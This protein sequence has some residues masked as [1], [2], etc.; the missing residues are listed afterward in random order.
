ML[1]GAFNNASSAMMAMSYGMGSI[2]Q[3]ISN[4]NTVGYKRKDTEF[5]TM[6]SESHSAPQTP[7][8][9]LSIFGVRPAD[10]TMVSQ[11]GQSIAGNS[12]SDL[13]INGRGFFI[14]SQPD[15]TGE[16]Q[17]SLSLTDNQ[18]ILYTRA[19]DFRE[20]AIGTAGTGTA[21]SSSSPSSSPGEAQKRY[22]VTAGGQFLMG[23][24]ADAWGRIPGVNTTYSSPVAASSGSSSAS[25]TLVPISVQPN[26]T[27]DGVT[28][29]IIQPVMNIPA[30]LEQTNGS[31]RTSTTVTDP[32]AGTHTMDVQWARDATD[33]NAWTVTY[34]LGDGSGT[35]A[36][37]TAVTYDSQGDILTPTGGL[38]QP[39]VAWQPLYGGVSA[40][41]AA[42]DLA[43][44]DAPLE[45][46]S[47]TFTIYDEKFNPQSVVAEFEHTGTDAWNMRIRPQSH[48]VETTNATT[49]ADVTATITGA[50]SAITYTSTTGTTTT[51]TAGVESVPIVFDGAGQ[52]VSPTDMTFTVDWTVSPA[53]TVLAPG[54]N[55][56]EVDMTKLT[57]FSD[58]TKKVF[59]KSVEQDGYGSGQL[60]N[61][62]FL[63][64]GELVGHFTNG[65]ARTLY[66]VPVATF[67]AP[68]SLESVSGTMFRYT[69]EAGEVSVAEIA[70]QGSG[71][72]MVA[73][74]LEAS[75]VE[76]EDE[77][78]RMIITQKAYSSNATVFKTADEMT[79]TARDLKG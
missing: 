9:G 17:T 39:T 23:W 58:P 70:D 65:N 30:N 6:L 28:T 27:L 59:I 7:G 2:S 52:I 69:A 68:N 64:T 19:G 51:T 78:T 18:N 72:S 77:F 46:E 67:V 25:S 35:I 75:T 20:L 44:L 5:K 63:G 12:W 24:K 60:D 14:V 79:T 32:L 8:G 29:T 45:S 48:T 21:T 66:V 53:G 36:A 15:T 73:N 33:P 49:G 3:N 38:D 22:L 76:L 71:A 40:Q 54:S 4:M 37:T 43:T 13:S 41:V 74:S 11:Q 56:V 50:I 62:E 57:Q 10:R 26:L 55:T 61:L 16:P 1:W 31:Y 42:I 47:T 34:S